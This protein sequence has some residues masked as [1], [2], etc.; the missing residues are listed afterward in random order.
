[1]FQTV[2]NCLELGAVHARL[3]IKILILLVANLSST[4]GLSGISC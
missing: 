2:E 1:M 4:A 3:A